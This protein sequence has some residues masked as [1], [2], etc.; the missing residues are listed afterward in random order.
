MADTYFTLEAPGQAE[1]T[2][3]GSRFLAE[4]VA[5]TSQTAAED[6]ISGVRAREHAATHHCFAYR[7]GAAGDTFRYNDDGEPSGTAGPP[8]LRRIDAHDL[9]NT[10]VVVTRY[11]G[12][13]ELGTG[14]LA[15]AYGHAAAAALERADLVQRV[16]RTAVQIRYAYDDTAPA[17]RVLQQFDALVHDSEYTDVTTLTV[18][19]RESQVEAFVD[20]FRNALS[21]R[22]ELLRVG[23]PEGD[24][25]G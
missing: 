15:R 13:T 8:I 16:V 11:F 7:V 3:D 17:E 12:G 20:A 6:A 22:G 25:E 18:G 9:T 21:D 4:A 1:H 24:T 23:G 2:V 10:L 19:V 5:V 14:G